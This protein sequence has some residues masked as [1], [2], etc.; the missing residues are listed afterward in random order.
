MND[1][2][3]REEL[4]IIDDDEINRGILENIFKKHYEI[5]QAEN[6]KRMAGKAFL[7]GHPLDEAAILG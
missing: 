3:E 5:L 1:L 4:L 7:L 2:S 6:G